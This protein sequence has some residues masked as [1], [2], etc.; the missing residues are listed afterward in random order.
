LTK[1][2]NIEKLIFFIKFVVNDC[3]EKRGEKS[4]WSIL[5]LHKIFVKNP[6]S[7][8][9]ERSGENGVPYLLRCAEEYEVEKKEQLFRLCVRNAPL[10]AFDKI[11]E[12]REFNKLLKIRKEEINLLTILLSK[13]I[14]CSP[15][16]HLILLAF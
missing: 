11:E 5:K 7:K 14:P 3:R 8:F 15:L 2:E 16:V 9:Y 12:A 4:A 1:P 13:H 6:Y 10:D